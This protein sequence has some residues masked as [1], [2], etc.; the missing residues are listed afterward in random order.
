LILRSNNFILN[1]R[2]SDLLGYPN[3]E[4]GVENMMHSEVFLMKFDV[5][6]IADETLS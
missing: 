2:D 5:F 4:K 6:W 1:K 3:I